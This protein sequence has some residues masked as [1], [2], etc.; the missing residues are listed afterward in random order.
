MDCPNS[1]MTAQLDSQST[2]FFSFVCLYPQSIYVFEVHLNDDD[3][4]DLAVYKSRYLNPRAY[5]HNFSFNNKSQMLT[6]YSQLPKSDEAEFH[7]FRLLSG[8]VE[9]RHKYRI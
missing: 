9:W 2:T 3:G 4:D 6:V 7:F 8:A 1:M 5:F